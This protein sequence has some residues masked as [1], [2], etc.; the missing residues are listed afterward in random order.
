MRILIHHD[1][2]LVNADHRYHAVAAASYPAFL[3]RYRRL[4]T[5][6]LVVAE[7]YVALRLALGHAVALRF[8]ICSM[9]VRASSAYPSTASSSLKLR[10]CFEN[11]TTNA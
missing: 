7:T 10:S 11:S 4:W 1:V 5:T 3:A 6:P 2:A 9:P 8:S